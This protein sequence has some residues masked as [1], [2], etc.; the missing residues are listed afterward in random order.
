MKTIPVRIII[1]LVA[2]A[3][4]VALYSAVHADSISFGTPYWVT[5]NWSNST[6]PPRGAQASPN[7]DGIACPGG[8]VQTGWRIIVDS[9]NGSSPYSGSEYGTQCRQPSLAVTTG[10]RTWVTS[11]WSNSTTPTYG[12]RASNNDGITCP[13]GSIQTGWRIVAIDPGMGVYE[14]GTQCQPLVSSITLDTPYWVISN[15]SSGSTPTGARASSNDGITCPNGSVQTGWRIIYT[16][17]NDAY[18]P[19]GSGGG[20]DSYEYGT[21]CRPISST[22]IPPPPPPPSSCNTNTAIYNTP[23]SYTFTVP[24]GVT[25]IRTVAIGGGGG[26]GAGAG[27]W[28]S[29]G[30]GGCGG[31]LTGGTMTVTPGQQITLQVGSGG[32]GGNGI[33]QCPIAGFP[34]CGTYSPA[35]DGSPGGDSRIGTFVA[36]GGSWGRT[37][38]YNLY[39]QHA[40]GTGGGSGGGGGGNGWPGFYGQPGWGGT[41][42]GQTNSQGSGGYCTGDGWSIDPGSFIKKVSYAAGEGGYAPPPRRPGI[43]FYGPG[44]YVYWGGG[45]GGG[46]VVNGFPTRGGDGQSSPGNGGE[47]YGAGGGG[48]NLDN[49]GAGGAGASGAVYIEWDGGGANSCTLS[50][51]VTFDQNPLTTGSTVMRWTSTGLTGSSDTFLINGVGYVGASGAAQVH[52][53]GDYS[54]TVTNVSGTMTCPATL[55]ASSCSSSVQ[56]CNATTGNLVNNCGQ[57]TTTCPYGCS[58]QT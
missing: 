53:A 42:G 27:G 8:S 33:D 18:A 43:N 41:A 21:Q 7:N 22:V 28:G 9:A 4:V 34:W 49:K 55:T 2:V 48:S 31:A 25:Q 1:S 15:S 37:G 3:M 29:G 23:G 52:F 45:G 35:E 38:F 16:S 6:S 14:Y 36:R 10:A 50:C 12:A 44:N 11:N 30:G 56:Y 17:W 20:Y 47:G 57:T 46:L 40:G 39:N 32:A 13:G 51:S 54:G 58:T 19:E 24:P 26:G 5:S